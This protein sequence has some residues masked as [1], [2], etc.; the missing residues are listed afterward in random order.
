MS[1][2][3]NENEELPVFDDESN[4]NSNEEGSKMGASTDANLE[5]LVKRLEKL[6]AENNKLRRK[7]KDKKTKKTLP[8]ANKKTP[9]MKRMSPRKGRK[10]EII[11]ISP[12]ITQCLSIM[13][14]C[15]ALSL[16]LPYP[17]A[18]LPILMEL[19]IIN[20]GIT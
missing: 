9:H 3:R 6:T 10:E 15:L 1:R 12:P 13:I 5:D 2:T 18:K 11:A 17:L 19:V 14:I 20:G 8:Q 7:A 4:T 16:T